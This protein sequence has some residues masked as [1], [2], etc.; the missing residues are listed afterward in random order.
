MKWQRNKT[1][2]IQRPIN[3][4]Q[5]NKY[6]TNNNNKNKQQILRHLSADKSQKKGKVS[7]TNKQKQ[8]PDNRSNLAA[9]Q[10]WT[11]PK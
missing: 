3:N 9:T 4:S 7:C 8:K 1:R 6:K 5:S 11:R 10:N 2:K